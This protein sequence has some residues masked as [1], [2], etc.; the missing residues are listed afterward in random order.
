MV[1]LPDHGHCKY[2]GDPTKFG[3]DYCDDDC[4]ALYNAREKAEKMKDLRFYALIAASIIALLVVG[5]IIN[6]V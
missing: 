4:K 5:V 3:D 6:T 1:Y 2:C